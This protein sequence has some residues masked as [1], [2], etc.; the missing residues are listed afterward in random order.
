M[1]RICKKCE[2]VIPNKVVIE[3][4]EYILAKRKY[5]LSCN[6]IFGKNHYVIRKQSKPLKNQK[7]CPICNK[8]FNY[9]KNDICSTCRN[10][11]LRSKNKN[12][13]V[14]ELG[15]RCLSCGI[16]DVDVLTFHH[17][18]PENKL[19]NISGNLNCISW[20][21]LRSEVKKCD[22]L[23]MNCHMKLHK[24]EDLERKEKIKKYYEGAP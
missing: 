18:E 13:C 16:D 4:K 17:R 10:F 1:S 20:D 24:I 22:L 8:K 2:C 5:C 14:V 15:G 6:P 3:K 12:K 23:C 9:T 11:W 21:V 19:F 7:E